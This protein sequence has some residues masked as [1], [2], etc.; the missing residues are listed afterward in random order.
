MRRLF[1][2]LPL[3]IALVACSQ[4][5]PEVPTATEEPVLEERRL[6]P[7][8]GPRFEPLPETFSSLT[9]SP[10]GG[11][12]QR[13]CGVTTAYFWENG[14]LFADRGLKATGFRILPDISFNAYDWID[15]SQLDLSQYRPYQE[16]IETFIAD[17]E[18]S[19]GRLG[20]L[21]ATEWPALENRITNLTAADF[22]TATCLAIPSGDNCWITPPF[23]LEGWDDPFS[24]DGCI[25]L[26]D[27]DFLDILPD[28]N[29]WVSVPGVPAPKVPIPLF[30]ESG[31][32]VPSDLANFFADVVSAVADIATV[33]L[34]LPGGGVVIPDFIKGIPALG[35]IPDTTLGNF[36]SYDPATVFSSISSALAT[37]KNF[38]S[39]DNPFIV[40][41]TDLYNDFVNPPG[42]VVNDTRRQPY[43]S[44]FQ[45]TWEYWALLNQRDLALYEPLNWTQFLSSHNAYNNVADGYPMPNQGFSLTDQLRMGARGL[46]L[47]I[48][49]YGGNLRLCHGKE[50]HMGCSLV[51][52]YYD[53]GIKE[54]ASWLRAN[55]GEVI[56]IDFEDRA[57]GHDSYVNDPIGA[58]LADLVYTPALG[59]ERG[60]TAPVDDN[61]TSQPRKQPWPSVDEIRA[62]GKQVLFFSDDQHGGQWL[63]SRQSN[64][65]QSARAK[66]FYVTDATYQPPSGQPTPV[67]SGAHSC[68]SYWGATDSSYD[69]TRGGT[70][71]DIG[72]WATVYEA[73]SVIDPFDESGL[74]TATDIAGV[75]ACHVT[76]IGLDFFN[77]TELTNPGV[78]A[79]EP[80]CQDRDERVA[81]AIWSWA[82]GD[83]GQGGSAA[84]LQGSTGRWRSTDP[85]SDHRFACS[86]TRQGPVGDRP[87][88]AGTQWK[89]TNGAGPWQQGGATCL[90]E[91]GAEG[92]VFGVPT[93]GWANA[94]LVAA[95]EH[96]ADVWLNYTDV[97]RA[98]EWRVNRHPSADTGGDQQRAEGEAFGFDG[99]TSV[100]LDGDALSYH[101]DFGD[102]TTATGPTPGHRYADDG[103]YT[104][105]LT[106]SDGF[107][108][109]DRTTAVVSVSN[110]PPSIG[111]I[112]QQRIG[113]G[114]RVTLMPATFSDPAFDCPSCATATRETFSA[115]IDWG[116]GTVTEGMLKFATGSPGNASLGT[117]WGN[118]RYG[119][120]GVY[121]ITVCVSD[122]DGGEGCGSFTVT[123]ANLAPS[124]TLDL[125]EAVTLPSGA[126]A[127]LVPRSARQRFA[128]AAGDP[129]SD[130]LRFQWQFPATAGGS[131]ASLQPHTVATFFNDGSGPDPSASPAGTY[132]FAAQAE[133]ITVFDRPGAFF[134]VV[135][136][137]D[138]D[139]DSADASL[140]VLV[141][142]LRSCVLTSTN[143]RFAYGAPV[144]RI[145]DSDHLAGY[146]E[147]VRLASAA[148]DDSNL[149]DFAA[150]VA[151]L[152]AGGSERGPLVALRRETLSAWLNFAAGGVGWADPVEAAGG[153]TFG[154]VM[155]L[156]ESVLLDQDASRQQVLEAERLLAGAHASSWRAASCG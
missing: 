148:F 127:V 64:P 32:Q 152:T 47:D 128:A 140:S 81:A 34:V 72:V 151:V 146:L 92:F 4:L 12:G 120:D 153:L 108:G 70:A 141:S 115:T 20:T 59:R 8:E 36:S 101:W 53:S 9:V 99:R 84:L 89:I 107:S 28:G 79:G 33:E 67:T 24:S 139:G 156:A 95:N 71:N 52:R 46:S 136:V 22:V 14:N 113:E 78:C 58:H 25:P 118:H 18:A 50:D 56:V 21:L 55:P 110:V 17:L 116:E 65:F 129:G 63:W 68:W 104:V 114:G 111:A 91:F 90:E 124:A 122:D 80:R 121:T 155:A 44:D 27:L 39:A 73:R 112:P 149:P 103:D 49:W 37:F 23:Q 40:T 94:R 150:T 29:C 60:F 134:A 132:P 51:D 96:G 131:P 42:V 93:N 54:L 85:N 143:W 105:T 57:E 117:V 126:K 119:D 11:E 5:G 26:K 38:F 133:L 77:A 2:F 102:G 147:V 61:D 76:S 45:E 86:L 106:V 138:D 83:S 62:E 82:P 6:A 19:I 31:W 154:Q 123:V 130:D 75:A 13:P 48:H 100:D 87:D 66:S 137:T 145:V 125:S 7:P 30:T 109:V 35:P 41:F 43:A 98:G 144:L 15:V 10:C 74:L 135:T 3:L 1:V 142:D 88:P 16:A 97:K 69:F